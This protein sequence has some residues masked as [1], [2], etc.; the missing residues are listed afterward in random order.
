MLGLSASRSDWFSKKKSRLQE[1][2]Y[3]VAVH[4]SG[5]LSALH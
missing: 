4:P 2:L 3:H 1:G 5:Q